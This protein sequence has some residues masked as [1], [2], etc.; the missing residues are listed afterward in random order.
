MYTMYTGT[1]KQCFSDE[2]GPKIFTING[3]LSGELVRQHPKL[4]I[5]VH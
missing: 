3:K 5:P 2:K 4:Q 1:Q